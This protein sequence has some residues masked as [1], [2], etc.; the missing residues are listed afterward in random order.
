MNR[1]QLYALT[2]VSVL[3]TAFLVTYG[4]PPFP[5]TTLPLPNAPVVYSMQV[6]EPPEVPA[7]FFEPPDDGFV[8]VEHAWR[9]LT[10]ATDVSTTSTS[11]TVEGTSEASEATTTTIEASVSN[12]TAS[13][14]PPSTVQ[15][16][17]R[18]DYE[19][20]FYGRINS[21][22]SSQGLPS[23]SR[24]G[25]LDARARDWARHLAES[26]S[27]QHSDIGSLVPPWTAAGENLG[28]GG[29]VAGVFDA[30]ASSGGH[31]SNMLGDFTHAGIGVW[32]DEDGTLW[33]VHL[34]ARE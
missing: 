8:E 21:L 2:V 5:H 18:S 22:R 34:F 1:S 14:S 17:F 11:T 3:L 16:G 28:S 26:G 30:L 33:T 24:E 31:R 7:T 10:I 19:A 25:S 15:A 12:T 32:V 6:E 23:L 13:T 4:S 27:L 29:S 9:A 20:D